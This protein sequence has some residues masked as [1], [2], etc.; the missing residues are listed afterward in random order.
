MEYYSTIVLA[1]FCLPLLH[2]DLPDVIAECYSTKGGK[3]RSRP[4]I[5]VHPLLDHVRWCA[6]LRHGQ[7][8]NAQ[9][10]IMRLRSQL[11]CK[12]ASFPGL[13]SSNVLGDWRPGNEASTKRCGQRVSEHGTRNQEP[14]RGTYE[15]WLWLAA[16][17]AGLVYVWGAGGETPTAL[18]SASSCKGGGIQLPHSSMM[19]LGS[20]R[21]RDWEGTLYVSAVLQGSGVIL[22]QQVISTIYFIFCVCS[23]LIS[24]HW[25]EVVTFAWSAINLIYIF[26][27]KTLRFWH[28]SDL[29]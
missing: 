19:T 2:N 7:C 24:R 8:S 14:E 22:Q 18:L 1:H 26:S 16:D 11:L 28:N 27:T 23:S 21:E 29:L 13:Q 12:V 25:Q 9:R 3:D 5:P 10:R 4:Y 6:V 17:G 20:Q 15:K